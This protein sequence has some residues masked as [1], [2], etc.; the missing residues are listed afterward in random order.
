MPEDDSVPTIKVSNEH[1]EK[2][3]GSSCR[4]SRS[5]H[6]YYRRRGHSHNV[7]GGSRNATRSRLASVINSDDDR[8]AS[9]RNGH[10]SNDL[11]N[12]RS[13]SD[14]GTDADD[15]SG[16]I[17]KS[18]PAPPIKSRKGFIGQDGH[19]TSSPLLTP[20]YLDDEDRRLALERQ[21]RRSHSDLQSV[22]TDDETRK[23]REK[24]TRRRRAEFLRRISETLLFGFVGYF[25][26]MHQFNTLLNERRSGNPFNQTYKC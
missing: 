8:A 19:G 10:I 13:T 7:Q 14:S 3:R 16:L 2:A 5:P 15:E 12:S 4:L 24:F 20:S 22:S 18:L 21:L 25:A 17:L 26:S 9:Y 1:T 6:P 23:V 11:I